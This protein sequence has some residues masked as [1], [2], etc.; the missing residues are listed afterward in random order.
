MVKLPS[1]MI[2]FNFQ[3]P[4][5]KAHQKIALDLIKGGG[6]F[7]NPDK[8]GYSCLHMAIMNNHRRIGVALVQSNC[9]MDTIGPDGKSLLNT[10]L[11]EL[12]SLSKSE[13]CWNSPRAQFLIFFVN[14][15]ITKKSDVMLD[16]E[17]GFYAVKLY[18]MEVS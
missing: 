8:N 16:H 14:L 18:S 10:M 3:P 12:S 17:L 9:N 7:N 13:R 15:F 2:R 5:R 6:N 11:N 4:L 1:V